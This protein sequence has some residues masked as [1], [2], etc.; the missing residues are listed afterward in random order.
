MCRENIGLSSNKSN[1]ESVEMHNYLFNNSDNNDYNNK[2]D[3]DDND[4]SKMVWIKKGEQKKEM[5]R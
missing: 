5:K 2:D 4:E 3:N 1:S